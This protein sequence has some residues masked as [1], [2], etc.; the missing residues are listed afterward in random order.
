MSLRH[1]LRHG[2]RRRSRLGFTLIEVLVVVAMIALLVAI[3]LPSLSRARDQAR[4]TQCTSN[5]R[6]I[7]Q[8]MVMYA[9][10]H[11]DLLPNSN[12]P[13]SFDPQG[14]INDEQNTRMFIFIYNRYLKSA[15]V[16]HCPSDQDP[17]PPTITTIDYL[18]SNSARVSYDYYSLWWMPEYGPKLTQV[19]Y[20]PL[21]WDHDG[22]S[23]KPTRMQNHGTLGGNVAY[24]DSHAGWLPQPQWEK[25]SWPKYAGRFYRPQ[26]KKR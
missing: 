10:A 22:G 24:S 19:K 14:A 15:E 17:V 5:L 26:K 4:R 18:A 20:A 25:K 23:I 1:S 7:V 21:A 2:H 8:A 6:S 3:L 13:G 11:R 12:L 16:F 9:D